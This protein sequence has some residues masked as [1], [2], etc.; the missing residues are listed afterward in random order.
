MVS[1]ERSGMCSMRKHFLDK[2]YCETKT[3][4]VARKQSWAP[5]ANVVCE[6]GRRSDV[7]HVTPTFTQRR[8]SNLCSFFAMTRILISAIQKSFLGSNHVL[9][10]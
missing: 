8:Y 9:N 3:R 7:M 10:L 1:Q 5:T 2:W 4:A 6:S